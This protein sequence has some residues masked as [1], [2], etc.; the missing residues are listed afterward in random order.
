[1]ATFR[2]VGTIHTFQRQD[3]RGHGRRAATTRTSPSAA[4]SQ[5]EGFGDYGFP[6]SHAASFA[7]LVYASSWIKCHYP[8][9][10][11]AGL[12]N[13]QPMGFYAPAQI[14]RDAREHGV[15]VREV[16]V[17]LSDWDATLE[18]LDD[19]SPLPGPP[20]QGGRE[21][22]I[23]ARHASQAADIR[24]RHAVRLGLRQ[25]KGLRE[26]EAAMLVA[27]REGTFAGVRDFWLR[28]GISRGGLE[29]LAE[30][31][32]FRSPGSTGAPRCGRCG[33][34]IA[35]QRRG[36]PA[37]LRRERAG[38]R[39]ERSAGQPSERAE[40]DPA[41]DAGGR[42]G[43]QRLPHAVAVAEGASGGF[44]RADLAE[45]GIVRAEELALL[46][47]GRRVK[48]AG[49]VL[50]RQRPG[51]AKGVIF[52]TLEDETGVANIIVWPKTFERFR[53]DRHRR[54]APRRHRAAAIGG[55]RHPRRGGL[56]GGPVA[57]P[58][59]A[60]APAARI[61]R[62]GASDEVRRP[63]DESYVKVKPGSR[64]ARTIAAEPDLS[65][66]LATMAKRA[67]SVM[68]K[69]RNFQ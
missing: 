24:T 45:R 25:V 12:L 64:L 55:G 58:G 50:V 30:A 62:A 66:E 46:K 31:D 60:V 32:A 27:A 44:L 5:I 10:F 56:H 16:D 59:A 1:M 54:A 9:V 22:T 19:P 38:Q 15:E 41:A 63:V 6:E 7:L 69:G 39:A 52:M 3:D 21:G 8:D 37:A 18:A 2:R 53:A 49:L 61:G 20:P 42:A 51:T 26:A 40:R 14:V 17:N 35:R 23:H 68:P 65:D 34:S 33:R 13:S 67:A 28:A 57:A 43:D 4:S 47:S 11:C 36:A 29:R 48:V